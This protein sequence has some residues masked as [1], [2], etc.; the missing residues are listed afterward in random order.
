MHPIV[1]S[2]WHQSKRGLVWQLLLLLC[3]SS[4]LQ[5]LFGPLG[6][7]LLLSPAVAAGI[8]VGTLSEEYSKGQLRF[9][10]SMPISPAGF[11]CVKVLS[12]IVGTS[13]VVA[14]VLLPALFLDRPTIEV[15]GLE[16]MGFSTGTFVA[17]LAGQAVVA[18]AAGL[19][20][21][22][23]CQVPA[24]ATTL[25]A[26]ISAIPFLA[27]LVAAV[28]AQVVPRGA[29]LAL[30]LAGASLPLGIGA[31]V[32][33]RCRNPFVDQPWRWRGIAALFGGL[34]GLAVIGV[35]YALTL[36]PAELTDPYRDGVYDYSVFGD[37]SK[38]FV[39]GRRGLVDVEAY[40]L[41]RD[42]GLIRDLFRTDR[43]L[44]L[45]PTRW[46]DATDSP[47]ILCWQTDVSL[48]RTN[49]PLKFVL[50]LDTGAQTPVRLPGETDR[51]TTYQYR[52]PTRDGRSLL[53]I[54]EVRK[55]DRSAYAVFRH[56]LTTSNF[57][58]IPI[59]ESQGGTS[60]HFLDDRRVL[61][62]EL[63]PA[64]PAERKL[65]L[66]ELD[67]E[68]R[69]VRQ[70][71]A[72]VRSAELAPDGRTCTVLRW[73]FHGDTI[74]QEL[75]ALDVATGCWTTVFTSEELP[76]LSA[77]D[78]LTDPQP[79][80]SISYPDEHS[81]D[82][83]VG[84]Y[85]REGT[86]RTGWLINARTGTRFALPEKC[87]HRFRLSKDGSR[88]FAWST[89]ENQEEPGHDRRQRRLSVYRLT[90]DRVELM[91]S[92]RWDVT[93]PEPSW[94]GNDRLLYHKRVKSGFLSDR[95]ELWTVAIETGQHRPF[96]TGSGARARSAAE[97]YR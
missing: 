48:N 29:D 13:L 64:K 83:M 65:T 36:H 63:W 35:C 16:Q 49:A 84:I 59:L 11:W 76:R 7:L 25:A 28:G 75:A 52:R 71:P 15:P 93:F 73:T 27:V 94:L 44:F 85:Y 10:Y 21:I 6:V 96:F 20:S 39:L 30:G 72:D 89:S 40:V 95:G 91:N 4:V 8:G 42:G 57:Q 87:E 55:G 67:S 62:P 56:E 1:F 41:D 90:N 77:R 47:M 81:P 37:D 12:G 23:F 74:Q 34:H 70:L 26:V 17:I 32:L 97:T 92:F 38:V 9:S 24:T 79:L 14:V 33:F 88:F 43:A 82:W 46:P 31:Y 69:T 86:A 3:A 53:G 18:Y 51:G 19:F 50:N 66:I 54:K 2:E 5:Y 78:A 60:F 22:G 58:E 45:R 80:P 61:L 68:M